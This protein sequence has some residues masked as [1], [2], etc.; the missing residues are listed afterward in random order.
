MASANFCI[1]SAY[2]PTDAVCLTG[3]IESSDSTATENL[4]N[5]ICMAL[6]PLVDTEV[7][8]GKDV[9]EE[10]EEEILS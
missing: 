5:R 6:L 3:S 9:D 8:M 7:G 4:F 1:T 10:D 2:W